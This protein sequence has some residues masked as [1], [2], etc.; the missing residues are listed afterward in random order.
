MTKKIAVTTISAAAVVVAVGVGTTVVAGT[1]DHS[2]KHAPHSQ[3]RI[4]EQF[5]NDDG[6]VQT[7]TTP[8]NYV[9]PADPVPVADTPADLTTDPA[10]TVATP[11]PAAPS[12]TPPIDPN[13]KPVE[14]TQVPIQWGNPGG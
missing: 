3:G 7:V 13:S 2:A 11:T 14:T 5:T 8:D 6:S 10:A 1:P 9:P 4:I 12:A